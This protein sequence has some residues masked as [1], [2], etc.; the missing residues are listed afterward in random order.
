MNGAIKWAIRRAM[1]VVAG[2]GVLAVPAVAA[3]TGIT[4]IRG[5]V[6][7]AASGQPGLGLPT[8]LRGWPPGAPRKA[9]EP[10]PKYDAPGWI[11]IAG[12]SM[13]LVDRSGPLIGCWLQGSTQVGEIDILCGRGDWR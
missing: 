6:S 7:D 4:V 5:A 10:E 2:L 11:A 13:W 1:I 12:E 8:V 9:A 3:D